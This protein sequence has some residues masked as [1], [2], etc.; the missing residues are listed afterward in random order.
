MTVARAACPRG[1]RAASGSPG[2]C[3][4]PPPRRDQDL[5][6]APRR[7]LEHIPGPEGR[8]GIHPGLPHH[9]GPFDREITRLLSLQEITALLTDCLEGSPWL[10]LP[11]LTV[12]RIDLV[13][14]HLVSASS[15]HAATSSPRSTSRTPR[16]LSVTADGQLV[17]GCLSCVRTA[18]QR[19]DP[20][21]GAPPERQAAHRSRPLQ[22]PRRPRLAL[23]ASRGVHGCRRLHEGPDPPRGA[24]PRGGDTPSHRRGIGHSEC[25]PG[26]IASVR[27]RGRE[28]TAADRGR[29]SRVSAGGTSGG[30]GAAGARWEVTVEPVW[31]TARY[32]VREARADSR[33]RCPALHRR[34]RCYLVLD[35]RQVFDILGLRKERLCRFLI[36]PELKNTT[37][38]SS[39]S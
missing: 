2:V 32:R 3:G 15:G 26:I 31:S 39:K 16:G 14:D 24:L 29:D 22:L 7:T 36:M 5:T 21:R 20:V 17:P 6:S 37:S 23:G 8:A 1:V 12:S 28:E 27:P 33:C 18:Q 19:C 25:S 9:R 30:S 35:R 4:P 10:R 34:C 38:L 13:S 11:G